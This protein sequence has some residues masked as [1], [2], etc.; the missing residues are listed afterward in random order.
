MATATQLKSLIKSHFENDAERFS[1]IVLQLAAHEARSGHRDMAIELR[2]LVDVNRTEKPKIRLLNR[3]LEELLL[4]STPSARLSELVLPA[5]LKLK[6]Q[7]ILREYKQRDKL[8]QH[9]YAYRRKIL[10]SGA[11]G[12]GKTMTASVI[13]KELNLPFFTIIVDKMVTKYMGETSAKLRLVFQQIKELKGVYLFDEFDA[14]GTQRG[15]DNEVGEM[16]RV[17]NAFLQ[18][19]EQDNSESF[20]I[21]A[22]N[23]IG[24]LDQALFRRFDDV[25]QYKLPSEKEMIQLINNRLGIFKG[26]FELENLPLSKMN[27]SHAEITQACDDAIKEAILDDKK[28]VSKKLLVEMLNDRYSPFS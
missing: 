10:L 5:E 19:L 16:R 21:G 23:N 20:I 22:T 28:S 2:E 12:T 26:R 1:T 27:L 3:E 6:I 17:L 13:A 14:I 7:R 25:L 11:P 4:S 18:F 8:S 24:L 9:G 15:R